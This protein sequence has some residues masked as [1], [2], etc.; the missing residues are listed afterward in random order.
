MDL[1][2]YDLYYIIGG[3]YIFIGLIT[4]EWAWANVKPIRKIDEERDSKYPAFRRWDA[5]KWRK[6]KFYFGAIT[7]MPLRILCSIL[8][9][10]VC[11]IFVRIFT[12]GHSFRGDTP[13]TGCRKHIVIFLIK[14]FCTGI[15]FF[16]GMRSS[17]KKVDF[18]YSAYLGPDYKKANNAPKYLSTYVS[19]HTSWLD[20]PVLIVNLK[21]AFASSEAFKKVPIFGIL[22]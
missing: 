12:I 18:D 20:I 8:L 15:L 17:R 10:L 1:G 19:N 4:F 22:V 16:A 13:L 6:W 11:Y 21:C 7:F 2:E 9:V 3:V 14:F 5:H